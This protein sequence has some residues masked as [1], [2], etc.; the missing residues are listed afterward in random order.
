MPIDSYIMEAFDQKSTESSDEILGRSAWSKI[1]SIEKYEEY[2]RKI[3]SIAGSEA[4]IDW[5][6]K[7]WV[8][9]AKKN[10]RWM[11]KSAKTSA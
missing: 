5:E 7:A 3:C 10:V 4:P 1:E 2:Q 6:G 9:I 11:I 8:R